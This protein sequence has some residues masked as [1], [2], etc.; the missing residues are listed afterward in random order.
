V[1]KSRLCDL[2]ASMEVT[3]ERMEYVQQ[4]DAT[5][6]KADASGRSFTDERDHL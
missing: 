2:L 5:N 4:T 6:G 3:G 1:D